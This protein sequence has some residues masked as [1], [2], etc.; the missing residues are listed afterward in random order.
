MK[1]TVDQLQRAIALK[2][3]II[4]EQGYATQDDTETL[5]NLRALLEAAE[6]R[7]RRA[8]APVNE[9]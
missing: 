8:G 5:L 1:P 7:A 9:S 6:W 2:Q 4:A 3:Q